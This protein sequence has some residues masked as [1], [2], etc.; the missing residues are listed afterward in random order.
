REP[1]CHCSYRMILHCVG[2]AWPAWISGPCDKLKG[3]VDSRCR[4]HGDRIRHRRPRETSFS[5]TAAVV[6][7]VAYD[8]QWSNCCG[9]RDFYGE[10]L[11]GEPA[12]YSQRGRRARIVL[13]ARHC[14]GRIAADRS[15]NRTATRL[16]FRR[17]EPG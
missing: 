6:P 11:C 15:R 14:R 12:V 16:W 3:V 8:L 9:E 7:A 13:A 4:D 17:D 2:G 5:L 1:G 10:D